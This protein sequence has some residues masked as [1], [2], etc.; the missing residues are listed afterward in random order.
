MIRGRDI[1]IRKHKTTGSGNWGKKAPERADGSLLS[2][3]LL[4][5]TS[6]PI[7]LAQLNLLP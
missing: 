3:V 7:F 5:S 2:L 6:V 1:W 4:P